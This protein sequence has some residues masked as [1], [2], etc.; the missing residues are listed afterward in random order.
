MAK[1]KQISLSLSFSLIEP[2]T[3]AA[4]WCR[5]SIFVDESILYLNQYM[6]CYGVISVS[7]D[8]LVALLRY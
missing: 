7:Y 5:R 2:M 3:T 6:R 8:G 1:R 4:D